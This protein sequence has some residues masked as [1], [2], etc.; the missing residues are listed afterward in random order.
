MQ[1]IKLLAGMRGTGLEK[2]PVPAQRIAF[3]KMVPLPH[4]RTRFLNQQAC[5]TQKIIRLRGE[6]YEGKLS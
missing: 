4:A 1:A 6:K 3:P 5:L 2:A